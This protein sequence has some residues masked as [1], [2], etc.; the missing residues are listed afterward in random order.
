MNKIWI[1]SDLHFCHDRQFIYGPRGFNSID[2]MNEA[3]VERWNSVVEPGDTVYVL[4]DIMLNDNEKGIALFEKL[5][6]F[7]HI[8]CGNH[9]TDAR[10]DLYL[11]TAIS[12]KYADVIKYRGYHFYLSHYPT[13]TANFEKTCLKQCMINL[14]G[15]THQQTN[16][17]N[18][19]PFMYHIG[20]DSHN[21]TPILLDDIIEECKNKVKECKEML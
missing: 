18:D 16:F 21:C 17:Y 15:H 6:G 11:R 1:T 7:K 12:V 13:M 5:N 20:M 2:E 10:R 14:Y 3:I 19:I 9:D 8:I 4:G